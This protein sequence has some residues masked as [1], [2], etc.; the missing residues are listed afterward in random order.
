MDGRA[1]VSGSAPDNIFLMRKGTRH[2][3]GNDRAATAL[4]VGRDI[5]SLRPIR[6]ISDDDMNLI[7]LGDEIKFEIEHVVVLMLENRSFDHLLGW[8]TRYEPDVNGI[9]PQN[10]S[11]FFNRWYDEQTWTPDLTRPPVP[12]TDRAGPITNPDPN[13]ELDAVAFQI[14]GALPNRSQPFPT[15][16]PQTLNEGAF[17]GSYQLVVANPRTNTSASTIMDCFDLGT[18]GGRRSQLPIYTDLA[19]SF[20]VFDRWHSSVPGPTIPNRLFMHAGTAGGYAKSPFQ[21]SL[22]ITEILGSLLTALQ[23]EDPNISDVFGSGGIA[24]ALN[25]IGGDPFNLI[26]RVLDSLSAGELG[27]ITN[28]IP[29]GVY[30]F[31]EANGKTWGIYFHDF[32]EAVLIRSL[33][34][35]FIADLRIGFDEGLPSSSNRFMREARGVARSQRSGFHSFSTLKKEADRLQ[36]PSLGVSLPGQPLPPPYTLPDYAFVTP[37]YIDSPDQD[38][39]W[40]GL[41]RAITDIQNEEASEFF[42]D[43]D[44]DPVEVL[45]SISATTVTQ[46]T[47][48]FGAMFKTNSGH[49]PD[50]FRGSELLLARTYDLLRNS[51]DWEKT[52]LVVIFDE[53]GGF[54][55]HV[56]PPPAANLTRESYDQL[57][58]GFRAQIDPTFNFE[59][60]GVRVPALVI[61]AW[62]PEATVSPALCDHTV[63]LDSVARLCGID[64]GQR[65]FARVG[66]EAPIA[67]VLTRTTARPDCPTGMEA[68]F[69]AAHP[70]YNERVP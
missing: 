2:L 21:D 64:V 13:H 43:S 18:P 61:S 44:D 67:D 7:P 27:K 66:N 15:N 53:H 45:R 26:A 41:R 47:S 40:V 19:R 11:D 65:R 32:T 20:A 6:V 57:T 49:P 58:P 50:D 39:I 9:D 5:H 63:L 69:A 8:L 54:Y 37:R 51:V 3:I 35:R 4:G 48:A 52:V 59:R 60:L 22:S 17:I 10:P 30:D 62:V 42:D 55:D 31:L 46:L 1:Y 14:S 36:P 38:A 70:D 23:K 16:L 28:S 34:D 25:A 24:A 12:A 29:A 33:R 68:R 56:T